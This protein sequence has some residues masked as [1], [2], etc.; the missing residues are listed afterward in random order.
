MNCCV[1]EYDDVFKEYLNFI[2]VMVIDMEMV[3]IFMVGFVNKIFIG[4]FLFVFDQLMML[5][6][7]KIFESD[8]CVMVGFVDWYLI[9]GIELLK[10]FKFYGYI[11]KYLCF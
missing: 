7:V 5:E 6:G 11:V 3:M 4:V 1:W 10:Q 2:W 9:I 8:L